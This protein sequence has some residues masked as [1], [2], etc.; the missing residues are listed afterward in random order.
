MDTKAR[1]ENDLKE[2]MRAHD[3]L[4]KRTLRLALSSIRFAE[5]EKGSE[6]DENGV[7]NILQ[8][9]VKSHL[10]SIEDAQRASRP[11]LEEIA[12]LEIDVLNNYL[13]SQMSAEELEALA[14]QVIVETGAN[15]PRDMG[16]VMKLL[17]PRL[18]GRASGDQASQA[19]RK[20]LQ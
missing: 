17:I 13:P 20:L 3:E 10:E 8:K 6:L 14:K 9:E 19:V 18:E 7:I 1:L 15:G 11:D 5:V 12:R 4:R 16:Q 2:A